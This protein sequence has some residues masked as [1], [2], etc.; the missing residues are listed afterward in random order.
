MA[1]LLG[2]F[3]VARQFLYQKFFLI[4]G[5]DGQQGDHHF[6][7]SWNG[8]G[9]TE[10]AAIVEICELVGLAVCP[11]N[12][13]YS[14]TF[15][16]AGRAT[17]SCLQNRGKAVSRDVHPRCVSMQPKGSIDLRVVNGEDD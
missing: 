1:G 7:W 13:R 6:H 4:P 14:V 9:P 3:S 2:I 16:A 8:A 5:A 11:S 17:S 15:A 10:Q 12:Y